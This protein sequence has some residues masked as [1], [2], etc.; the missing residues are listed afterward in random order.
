MS[1]WHVPLSLHT[2]E[3]SNNLSTDCWSVNDY[4][5]HNP[6]H[7]ES[8]TIPRRLQNCLS[9]KITVVPR[10]LSGVVK[11]SRNTCRWPVRTLS[12]APLR[13]SVTLPS[14]TRQPSR[15][16]WK[17]L[18]FGTSRRLFHHSKISDD[19]VVSRDGLSISDTSSW[20]DFCFS[21]ERVSTGE[22]SMGQRVSSNEWVLITTWKNQC[23]PLG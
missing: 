9:N 12:G 16:H 8:T 6:R 10:T 22:T 21:P 17:S 5:H 20:F 13:S 7:H 3:Y 2:H 14:S 11:L 4:T 15:Y 1:P 23:G 18:G 19:F